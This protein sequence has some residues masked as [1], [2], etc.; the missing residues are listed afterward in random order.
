MWLEGL[1]VM[2]IGG[3]G[4]R[5]MWKAERVG[6]RGWRVLGGRDAGRSAGMGINTAGDGKVGVDGCLGNEA[7]VRSTGVERGGVDAAM[8]RL[9]FPTPFTGVESVGVIAVTA[10][11]VPFTADCFR[12]IFGVCNPDVPDARNKAVGVHGPVDDGIV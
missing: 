4:G 7:G 1:G 5:V 6:G 9:V 12:A 2:E 11:L 10:W 3:E 8:P